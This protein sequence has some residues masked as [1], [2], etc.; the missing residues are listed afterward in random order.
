MHEELTDIELVQRYFKIDEKK[1]QVMIDKGL[2]LN[3]IRSG[4][5]KS[6]QERLK[7]KYQST[8]DDIIEDELVD[9]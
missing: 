8:V 2:D 5:I 3:Y 1:A 9:T 6:E 4:Y 7:D